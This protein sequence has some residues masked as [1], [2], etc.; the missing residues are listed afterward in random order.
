MES[1]LRS[2]WV[3]LRTFVGFWFAFL[4]A[5]ACNT[6]IP[7]DALRESW[8]FKHFITDSMIDL[9]LRFLKAAVPSG[10]LDITGAILSLL[11]TTSVSFLGYFKEIFV[12][13]TLFHFTPI[14]QGM[15][16]LT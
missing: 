4:C 7:L 8:I 1:G 14:L 12:I 2:L 11:Y 6:L 3:S 10:K 5:T 13:V 9:R 16:P 15:V